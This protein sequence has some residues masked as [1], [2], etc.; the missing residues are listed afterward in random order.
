MFV[1]YNPNPDEKSVGDCVVRAITK[2]LDMT[3]EDAYVELCLQGY[4]MHDMPS[5]N[6]VWGAYL[7]KNGFKREILSN[8]CADCYTIEDFTKEFPKGVYVVCTG[9]HA[10][11]VIDGNYY[12]S[13]RSGS[14]AA[15]YYFEKK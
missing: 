2:V 6:A 9:T 10:A 13:W 1:E 12:D 4:M 15:L 14:E 3:W 5:S 7:K 8:S 11:A